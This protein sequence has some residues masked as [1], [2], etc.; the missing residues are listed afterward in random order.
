M[1]DRKTWIVLLLC[2]GMLGLNW[3]FSQQQVKQKQIEQQAAFAKQAAQ[4]PA[5]TPLETP[6]LSA[7]PA[8]P[9]TEEQIQVLQN[10]DI[11]FNLTNIGAGVKCADFKREF[12]VHDKSQSVRQNSRGKGA[13][14]AILYADHSV[15]QTPYAYSTEESV[16][17]KKVVYLAKLPSGLIAKKTY[18][19]LDSTEPG[20]RYLLN[21][22]LELE[23]TSQAPISLNNFSLYLG[24]ASPLYQNETVSQTGFFWHE[25][26]SMTFK[27]CSVF[28]GGLFSE[29][30]PSFS[31]TPSNGIEYAGVTNQFFTTLIRQL[32]PTLST[33]Q[34]EKIV[35]QLQPG[36][37]ALS[38]VQAS[39]TLPSAFIAPGKS[40]AFDYQVFIGPKHNPMLRNME[41]SFGKGWGD[42]MQYG[43]WLQIVARPL[44]SLLNFYHNL[45][46][47]YAKNWAWGLAIIL[48]TIT[49]RTILWIPHAKSTRSMK[50]MS[51]LK[52]EMD[53]IREKFGDDPQKM[54]T[55]TMGLYRKYGIN[56]IGGCLPMLLQIPVFFGFFKMLQYAVELRHQ[57]FLWVNDLSQPDTLKFIDLPFA[58]PL[59]GSHIPINIL[60][61]VMMITSVLQMRMMPKTGDQNQQRMMQFMPLLFFFF[62]YNYASA[63]A[64]YWTTQNIF[65]IIQTWIMNRVPEPELVARAPSSKGTFMQRMAERQT[66]MQQQAKSRQAGKTVIDAEEVPRKRTPRTG[67]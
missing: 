11:A 25:N 54:N 6:S 64:L 34:A 44:N 47:G 42:I 10:D 13:I 50:R 33:I 3:H 31:Q 20:S 2:A 37:K 26:N 14:G 45:I 58:L 40:E 32:K 56:P 19:L 1:Y 67:G 22:K 27:S 24:E 30:K 63:L 8:L 5:A 46:A 60:P 28:S 4:A 17:G 48:L 61:V 35:V 52:P 29:A 49:I 39:F 23:N 55:E 66:A 7:E 15:D 16:A 51:K 21:Y 62:C 57:P 53:K 12:Q 36:Q 9:P 41:K 65:S 43:S 18:S 59:L 38:G